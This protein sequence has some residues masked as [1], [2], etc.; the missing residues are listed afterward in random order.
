MKQFKE[1]NLEECINKQFELNW[2]DNTYSKLLSSGEWK[3]Q[4]FTKYNTNKEIE[5]KFREWLISYLIKELS[6]P[7]KV[8]IR[9]AEWFILNWWFII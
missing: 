1:E 6:T 5:D 4:W 8:A 9:N 3:E 2:I 7:K